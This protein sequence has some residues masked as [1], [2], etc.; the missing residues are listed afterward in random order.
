MF[1]NEN[2]LQGIYIHFSFTDWV[3][4]ENISSIKEIDII[5]IYLYSVENT[6]KNKQN[7]IL[8]TK[9]WKLN[10]ILFHEG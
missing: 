1:L 7:N 3:F 9:M 8:F 5:I 4:V 2:W 10:K 6:T